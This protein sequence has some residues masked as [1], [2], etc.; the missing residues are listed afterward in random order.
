VATTLRGAHRD[1]RYTIPILTVDMLQPAHETRLWST[2]QI[3]L[4]DFTGR[5]GEGARISGGFRFEERGPQ[6]F[7]EAQVARV[8]PSRKMLGAAINWLS[9]DGEKMLELNNQVKP[10]EAPLQVKTLRVNLMHSSINWSLS[11]MLVDQFF[12]DLP[13]G[14]QVRGLVRL[15]KSLQAAVFPATV[16]R[17]NLERHTLALKFNSLPPETF[18]LLENAMKKGS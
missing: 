10:E 5:I 17:A 1:K 6:G 8:D 4:R 7:F 16:I 13:G 14:Q 11:G 12:T 18:A 3:I 9:A 15:Q 2:K